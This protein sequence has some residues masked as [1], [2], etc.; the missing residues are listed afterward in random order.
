[1]AGKIGNK[2]AEIWTRDE[3]QKFINSIYTY[4][5]DDVKCTSLEKACCELGQ[6][7]SLL[8][9]LEHK[10]IEMDLVPIKKAMA[11]IK[12]RLIENGLTNK[13]NPTMCIFILKNNHGM[14]DKNELDIGQIQINWHE[15]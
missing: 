10:Y 8:G 14:K 5:E 13:Y 15:E 11:L 2:N 4:V 6:Y 1:M 7:E 3:A 9:Y 12:E